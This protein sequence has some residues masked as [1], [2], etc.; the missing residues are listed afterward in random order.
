[1]A[2]SLIIER[3]QLEE[4]IGQGGIGTVYRAHDSLLDRDVAVKVVNKASLGDK[5]RAR[6]LREAKAIAKLNH[7]NIVMVFDAGEINDSPFIVEELVVG[8]SLRDHHPKDLDE[9]MFIIRQICAALEHAHENGIIH[10][11]LKPENIMVQE[12]TGVG[13]TIKIFDFGLAKLLDGQQSM[14]LSSVVAGTPNYMS[15]EQTLHRR[16][17][18]TPASDIFSLGVVFYQ[19]MTG[20]LPFYADSVEALYDMIRSEVPAPI[21]E[22]N[23]EIPESLSAI[24]AGML[25]KKISEKTSQIRQIQARQRVR[26]ENRKDIIFQVNRNNRFRRWQRL[27]RLVIST[28]G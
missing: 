17:K 16:D 23:A 4:E 28:T 26:V 14:T 6:L 13:E 18:L 24:C 1:M 7:P 8:R 5:D 2:D 20:R 25:E 19:M 11:D 3:Y 10:R 22:I 9:I 21:H 15:P 12:A 27:S